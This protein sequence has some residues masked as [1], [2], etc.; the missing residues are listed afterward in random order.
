MRYNRHEAFRYEFEKPLTALFQIVEIDDESVSSSKGEAE[1]INIS[2]KGIK[3]NS[4]L[5]IPKT[6]DKSIYLAIS[7]ELND[8]PLNVEGV[9][10]W[11]KTK[12]KSVDYGID[13]HMDESAEKEL[14]DQ[15]KMYSKRAHHL[16]E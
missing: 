12:G 2:P 11:K 4:K 9:I 14:I 10:V 15:L 7:F 1:I 5:N 13:L 6:D 16:E 8:K 3:L